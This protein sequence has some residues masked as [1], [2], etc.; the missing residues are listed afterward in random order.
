MRL[1]YQFRNRKMT[2]HTTDPSARADLRKRFETTMLRH[3]QGLLRYAARILQDA[4]TDAAD[5]VQDT[6]LAAWLHFE[7]LHSDAVSTWLYCTLSHYCM[8]ALRRSKRRGTDANEVVEPMADGS[9]DTDL[10][11]QE[12]VALLRKVMCMLSMRQR[13]IFSLFYIEEKSLREIASIVGQNT[14]QVKANLYVARR[15]V[16]TLLTR[17]DF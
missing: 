12:T 2:F 4:D 5:V 14:I 17:Y 3:E 1:E 11:R 15:K 16:R 8:D 6:F 7:D 9:A 13:M 10:E